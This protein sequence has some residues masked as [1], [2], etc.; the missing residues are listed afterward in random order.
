MVHNNYVTISYVLYNLD[1][2]SL[3]QNKHYMMGGENELM[4]NIL[5]INKEPVYYKDNQ[6]V[7]FILLKISVLKTILGIFFFAV[8][9]YIL[10]LRK[11]HQRFAPKLIFAPC[12]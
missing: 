8:N 12:G 2:V 3:L 7:N 6:R 11:C 9:D 4:Y 10:R 1:T 5:Y